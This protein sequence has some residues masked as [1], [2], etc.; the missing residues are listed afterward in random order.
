[1][2]NKEQITLEEKITEF[3]AY[4]KAMKKPIKLLDRWRRT[5]NKLS[6]DNEDTAIKILDQSMDRQWYGIFE[7]RKPIQ[8]PTFVDNVINKQNQLND[9]F[10][11]LENEY[12][13]NQSI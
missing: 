13:N 7:L 1:M 8:K 11:T 10:K 3:I 5:L 12:G 2:E 4:R 9:L 6:N